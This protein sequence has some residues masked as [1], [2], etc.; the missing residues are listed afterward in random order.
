MEN[1]RVPSKDIRKWIFLEEIPM[2]FEILLI[3]QHFPPDK[4]GNASRIYDLSRNLVQLG[5]QVTVVSPYPSFPHGS[6]KRIWKLHDCKKID[7]V[8]LINLFT[9]QPATSDP[10]FISRMGYYLMFPLHALL[11]ALLNQKEYDVII[12]TAPPIFT[13][14]TGFFIKKLTEKTWFF[15]VRD[16]WIDASIDLRFIKKNSRFEK[17]SRRYE[18]A[19][20]TSCDGISVTTEE[21]KHVIQT[22]YDIP[23]RKIT[24][25][26][27][28][29]D[30]RTFKPLRTK[31]DRIIYAGN[32]GHAQDLEK[33]VLAVK[34]LNERFPMQL[35]LVG[36]GDIKKELEELVKREDMDGT[37]VFTGGLSREKIP[38]LIAQSRLGVA[39]LKN[40]ISLRYAIPTKAYEYMACGIPFVGTGSGEIENLVKASEGGV[41][42]ESTVDSIYH[43]LLRLLENGDL[44]EKLGKNGRKFVEKF[45]D[46]RKIAEQLLQTI[47]KVVV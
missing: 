32:I 26:P 5:A 29:V 21:V 20:Y 23:A 44:M 15:D 2:K 42:A 31:K 41:V 45:Y 3:T 34:K 40:L 27:N 25:V 12:T 17:I 16:L 30:T 38:C 22:Q 36:D 39:P 1:R 8:K 4:S 9:W 13:G 46:R 33:V 18:K 28:G 43:N 35:F 24:I 7:G 6:F 10:S 11:W 19:C 14:I 47:K 37:V